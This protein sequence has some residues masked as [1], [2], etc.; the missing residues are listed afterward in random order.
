MDV[1]TEACDML[2]QHRVE[3]KFRGKK[4]DGILNRLHVAEPTARD[5]KSRP[6]FIPEAAIKKRLQKEEEKME[7]DEDDDENDDTADAADK[8]TFK[9]ERQIELE[10]G[11]DYILDLKKKYDLANPD[12][13]YDIV[14]ETWNGHNIADFIDPDIMEKLDA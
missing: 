1:K 4:V 10:Q 6:V 9:T 7:R 12:E 8:D 3:A 11:D 13:K 5:T 14:P 2:L